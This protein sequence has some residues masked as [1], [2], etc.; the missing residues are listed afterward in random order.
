[1]MIL[2]LVYSKFS[3]NANYYDYL[4]NQGVGFSSNFLLIL[5]VFGAYRVGL[6]SRTFKSYLFHN[7]QDLQ[8]YF[9]LSIF[10]SNTLWGEHKKIRNACLSITC[11]STAKILVQV[12]KPRSRSS[13]RRWPWP[14][15]SPGSFKLTH[16]I[17]FLFICHLVSWSSLSGQLHSWGRWSHFSGAVSAGSKPST[18]DLAVPPKF[19]WQ[20]SVSSREG[21]MRSG[22]SQPITNHTASQSAVMALGAVRSHSRNP[23]HP[24]QPS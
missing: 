20:K 1:M 7:L 24:L 23:F 6:Q 15:G 13:H 5:T 14:C 10:L 18:E 2:M 9:L 17:T 21:E 8:I 16:S 4:R 3:R 19:E 22:S 11:I 12:L